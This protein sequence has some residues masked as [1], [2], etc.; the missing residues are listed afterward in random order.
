MTEPTRCGSCG[1]AMKPGADGR[2]YVC[3]YCGTEVQ[4]AIG[5]E[6]VAAAM[7]FDR[8]NVESFFADLATALHGQLGERTRLQLEGRRVS[9]FELDLDPDRFVVRREGH[10]LVAQVKKVVRGVALKT[11][12]HPLDRWVELL[13]AALA[14]HA[15]ENA[16]RWGSRVG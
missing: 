8:A 5:A 12:I 7:R 1:A 9:I 6:Q 2:R 15:N 14:A 4:A 10:A 13:S 16:T 3:Q 11:H